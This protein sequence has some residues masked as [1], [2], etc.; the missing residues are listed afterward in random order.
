[1]SIKGVFFLKVINFLNNPGPYEKIL[2]SFINPIQ[3][4]LNN[5]IIS[6]RP[7]SDAVNIHFFRDLKEDD[8]GIN[9]FMSHGIADKKWRN[10][11]KVK[12]FDYICVSG[13]AWVKKMLNEGIPKEKILLIGYPKLDPLFQDVCKSKKQ[14]KLSVLWVPTHSNSI[15]SFPNFQKNI[16]DFPSDINLSISLHPFNNKDNQ[17][18]LQNIVNADVVIADFGSLIYEAWALDKPVVFPDWLLKKN[19]LRKY[20]N[21]FEEKIFLEDIGY[22]AKDFEHLLELVY[23]SAKNGLDLKTKKFIDDIFPKHLRGYSGLEAAKQLLR[24]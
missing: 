13:P 10:G 22:H 7:K 2:N 3:K 11:K 5:S 18:A 24:I 14:D 23:L 20:P 4:H 17:Y 21:S 19:V 9:V 16:D 12:D 8:P 6:P 15:S 1:M